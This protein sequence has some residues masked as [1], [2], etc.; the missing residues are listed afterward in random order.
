MTAAS[1]LFALGVGYYS[2]FQS[3]AQRQA[4]EK[5]GEMGPENPMASSGTSAP[6]EMNNLSDKLHSPVPSGDVDAGN[7]D[8]I[9]EPPSSLSF[10]DNSENE[11]IVSDKTNIPGNDINRLTLTS[12][13]K[14][15][16]RRLPAYGSPFIPRYPAFRNIGSIIMETASIR[17]TSKELWAG[18]NMASGIFD[19]NVTYGQRTS[20]IG[21]VFAAGSDSRQDAA[22]SN[23]SQYLDPE[24]P[25]YNARI[26]Y[27]YGLNIGARLTD[28]WILTGGVGYQLSKSSTTVNK[29]VQTGDEA[30]RYAYQSN[31]TDF[32]NLDGVKSLNLAEAE[33]DYDSYYEFLSVPVNAGYI[34]I[35]NK[36]KWIIN[37]GI[38]TEFFIKN[39]LS[40]PDNFLE[41]VEIYPG[42]ESP[43]N[44]MLF[45][46]S[47]GTSIYLPFLKNYQV[48][49]FPSYRFGLNYLTRENASFNS[50]PS[51]VMINAG[52][53][54]IFK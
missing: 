8:Y 14:V 28:K 35:D 22:L 38:S 39:R 53:S 2:F 49:L 6:D 47:F 51:A 30:A 25:E 48:V 10:T 11:A 20:P 36:L 26:S 24:K 5:A 7:K 54:Y 31:G 4:T 46:G 45:S 19:P 29:Y 50:K 33:I 43:Y 17:K 41:S 16:K 13:E 1:F 23:N 37:G 3:P 52:V 42:E 40:D 21:S 12:Q 44:S 15:L 27:S 34:L 32:Y 9:Q 18:I